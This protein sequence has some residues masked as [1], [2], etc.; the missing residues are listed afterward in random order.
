MQKNNNIATE[1]QTFSRMHYLMGT[2]VQIE[3]SGEGKGQVVRA[4]EEAF[5][6]MK[7]I[8]RLLSKYSE[9]SSTFR[10]NQS[11]DLSPIEVSLEVFK[12]I[13]E[14]VKYSNLT[15]GAFDIT[16]SPLMDLWGLSQER[17]SI[18]SNEEIRQATSKV[19]YT[20]IVLNPQY[21]TIFFKQRDMKLDFGAVGKGYAID[22]AI[23][24]LKRNNIKKALINTG[25]NIFCLADDYSRVGVKNPLRPEDIIASVALK[26]N[27]IS[28]SANYE[29]FFS[30]NGK[31]Y[32]H[33]IS[34]KTGYPIG[35]SILSVSIISPSA[36]IADILSTAVFILGQ[37]KGMEL[38]EGMN[39]VEGIL[40]TKTG[41]ILRFTQ[42][43]GSEK[44][45]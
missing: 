22:M 35:N 6:E 9:E 7:R 4:I 25:G 20:N 31:R 29:R 32:G 15:G 10:I 28:T 43:E 40:I 8:E 30:I 41:E 24:V 5:S 27:A 39:D 18:P 38:I 21:K 42:D 23:D 16:V 3:A 12:I 19:G 14:S 11:A 2:F 37:H 33:L 1:D 13:E 44:R 26:N 17:G 45:I 36:Q 34:P